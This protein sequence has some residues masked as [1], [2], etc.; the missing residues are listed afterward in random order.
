M[1]E[2]LAVI[3]VSVVFMFSFKSFVVSGLTFR[4]LIHL[5]S[6]FVCG[7]RKCSSVILLQMVDQF[8]SITC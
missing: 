2:D 8:S 4:S 7:V 5:K 6:I 3:Y 1:I